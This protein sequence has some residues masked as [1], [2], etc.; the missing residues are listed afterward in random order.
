MS[1]AQL[2]SWPIRTYMIRASSLP[3]WSHLT[4][5]LYSLSSGQSGLLAETWRY[6]ASSSLGDFT[7]CS[8]WF[9]HLHSCLP[10]LRCLPKC[11]IKD[12][13][14]KLALPPIYCALC[15]FKALII[16]WLIIWF[17]SL[18][19]KHHESRA[20]IS[21]YSFPSSWSSAW[22]SVL[23]IKNLEQ[24]IPWRSRVRTPYFHCR[25]T[26]QIPSQGTKGFLGGS[27]VKT[28]YLQCRRHRFNPWVG[29]IP[30][31][32]AWQP[33]PVFLPG[34][35]RRQ[36]SLVDYSSWGQTGLRN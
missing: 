13:L 5:S 16:M 35:S 10:H 14:Y 7:P 21:W 19:C 1:K 6:P 9:T 34:E 31:R 27:A 32:R 4:L 33:S 29:K 3:L 2:F 17:Y 30:W 8:L 26:G 20:G 24:G 11:H 25:I 22:Y 23:L 18:E 36:R 28:I 15:L 12:N